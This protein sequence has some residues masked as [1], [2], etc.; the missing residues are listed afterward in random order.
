MTFVSQSSPAI[1]EGRDLVMMLRQKRDEPY[2][3]EP[4]NFSPW[5]VLSHQLVEDRARKSKQAKADAELRRQLFTVQKV[6]KEATRREE[7]RQCLIL[8]C[9]STL[10]VTAACD[11]W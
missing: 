7:V 11:W 2:I 6:H 9:V 5:D 4:L 10:A 3:D 8:V 1:S